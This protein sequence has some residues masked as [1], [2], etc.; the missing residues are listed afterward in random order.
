M[1][2]FDVFEKNPNK[3]GNK[4]IGTH[5]YPTREE[6]ENAKYVISHWPKKEY[7]YIPREN[8]KKVKKVLGGYS[9]SDIVED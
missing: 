7:E 5:K 9:T 4:K 6:A 8:A 3:K 1:Y 2:K